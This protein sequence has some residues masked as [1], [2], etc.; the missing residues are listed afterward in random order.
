MLIY[1]VTLSQISILPA[2]QGDDLFYIMLCLERPKRCWSMFRCQSCFSVVFY[3][4][5]VQLGAVAEGN[6]GKKG[7]MLGW[8]PVLSQGSFLSLPIVQGYICTCMS[9]IPIG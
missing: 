7:A 9:D 3:A 6:S 5:R 2:G 1:R 8:N 4:K